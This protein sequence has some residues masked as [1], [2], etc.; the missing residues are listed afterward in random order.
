MYKYTHVI[1]VYI[2]R[3]HILYC[4]IGYIM[5]VY[6]YIYFFFWVY[7]I[8]SDDGNIY[9]NALY[10]MVK[11]LVSCRSSLKP[12]HWIFTLNCR[13]GFNRYLPILHY[14]M[15]HRPFVDHVLPGSPT[16][17]VHS[18]FVYVSWRVAR[19]WWTHCIS[20]LLSY[21]NIYPGW[22]FHGIFN[23]PYIGNVIIPTD[24][25]IFLR[26]WNHQ[27]VTYSK[28]PCSLVA[29]WFCWVLSLV[30]WHL[31]TVK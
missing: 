19:L 23:F 8:E 15:E 25:H 1:Y 6:I 4:I 5:Y 27:P 14:R 10:L 9:R 2:Y 30:I 17:N 7:F 31:G 20:S 16:M 21:S 12:I 28:L 24:F 3:L 26:G 18:V 11:T 29:I 22:W 13:S